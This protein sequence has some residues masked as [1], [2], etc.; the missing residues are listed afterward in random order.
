MTAVRALL[1]EAVVAGTAQRVQSLV[2]ALLVGAMCA[3]VLL[4][5]GKSVGAQGRVISAF[6]E[7]G[8]RT[9]VVRADEAA[10]IRPQVLD[11]L[12]DID[13]VNWF[14]AFGPADDVTNIRIEGGDR[15]PLRV[16]W[17]DGLEAF[18]IPPNVAVPGA[19]AWGSEAALQKL[20]IDARGGDVGTAD[21]QVATVMGVLTVPES[22]RQFE[23]LLLAP[24]PPTRG[25]RVG[26]VVIV[27]DAVAHVE[28]VRDL[29]SSIIV[30]ADGGSVRVSIS[31]EL[32]QLRES[33]DV[34][35]SDFS[36]ALVA[37]ILSGSALIVSAVLSGFVL[38]RRKD[39]GRRRALGATRGLI[40]AL[41]L[42]Q[43]TVPAIGGA[44]VGT[45]VAIMVLWLGGDP[46]PGAGYSIAVAVLAVV[47]CV[48]GAIVPAMVASRRDPLK[49]LRVP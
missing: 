5:A 33:V 13:A 49:E 31:E 4:T 40:I 48:V 23:P 42:L 25:G 27:V 10:A 44:V 15:I 41:V 17:G 35:L 30:P 36:A 47:A 18:G 45:A 29:V 46:P 37:I 8:A 43:S 9:I 7:S 14:A 32:A 28:V 22:M 38:Q 16:V 19:M 26:L 24:E 12:D 34:E 1:R 2:T 3:A 20:G 11:R 21:G 6:D 39:Y